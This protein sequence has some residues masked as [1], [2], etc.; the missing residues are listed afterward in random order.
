MIS[1]DNLGSVAVLGGASADQFSPDGIVTAITSE[2]V[3]NFVI[4][5]LTFGA[6]VTLALG[7]GAIVILITNCHKLWL[8]FKK[9]KD[10]IGKAKLGRGE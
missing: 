2:A 1:K 3:N 7:L 9:S 6:W 10:E 4:F 5:G 8:S